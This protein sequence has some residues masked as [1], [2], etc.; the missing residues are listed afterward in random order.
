VEWEGEEKRAGEGEGRGEGKRRRQG[1]G[2]GRGAF[3][4][5]F[6]LQFNHWLRE[7]VIEDLA[8]GVETMNSSRM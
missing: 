3:P 1:K 4:H 7:F 8:G 6:F 5:L 2:G